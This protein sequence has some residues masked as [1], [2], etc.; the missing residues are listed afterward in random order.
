MGNHVQTFLAVSLL[1]MTKNT[2]IDDSN[3]LHMGDK[4]IDHDLFLPLFV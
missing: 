3:P 1:Q 2:E 4:F